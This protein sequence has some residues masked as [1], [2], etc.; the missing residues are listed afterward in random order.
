VFDY[1]LGRF[2]GVDP[3][4]QFPLNSQSLNPYSYILNN[5]LSGTDP[6]GYMFRD[7]CNGRQSCEMQRKP[8]SQLQSDINSAR[9]DTGATRAPGRWLNQGLG[10][11]VVGSVQNVAANGATGAGERKDQAA[12]GSAKGAASNAP[13]FSSRTLGESPRAGESGAKADGLVSIGGVS[14]FSD[15]PQGMA[16]K[17]ISFDTR[18]DAVKEMILSLGYVD[19]DMSNVFVS[20]MYF[21]SVGSSGRTYDNKSVLAG[22]ERWTGRLTFYPPAFE[23]GYYALGSVMDHEIPHV[24]QFVANGPYK[25]SNDRSLREFEA[26]KYQSGRSNFRKSPDEFKRHQLGGWRAEIND[27]RIDIKSPSANYGCGKGAICIDMN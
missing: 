25:D 23:Y 4:I 26:Y 5:P 2:T 12:Q 10:S 9:G 27:Y 7:A 16:G 18:L 11:V 13:A 20:A 8:L 19:I 3:F 21:Q 1:N 17:L 22:V 24:R 15:A 14:D 6:S